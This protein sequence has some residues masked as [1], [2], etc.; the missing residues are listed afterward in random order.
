MNAIV[1]CLICTPLLKPFFTTDSYE[2]FL[3][4]KSSSLVIELAGLMK[5]TDKKKIVR[6]AKFKSSINKELTQFYGFEQCDAQE[7][8]MYFLNKISEDLRRFQ[9]E[10]SK[11]NKKKNYKELKP[12]D[13]QAGKEISS[14]DKSDDN[15][16][17]SENHISPSKVELNES[18]EKIDEGK[19]RVLVINKPLAFSEDEIKPSNHRGKSTNS[20]MTKNE[21]TKAWDKDNKAI[22]SPIKDLFAGQTACTV[23]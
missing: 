6:P 3:H 22:D 8:L 15:S 1:Q 13:E 18:E 4:S 7:F 9:T 5:E 11:E 19:G 12:L 17:N 14:D 20:E 10:N 2:K 16:K 23:T 21:A